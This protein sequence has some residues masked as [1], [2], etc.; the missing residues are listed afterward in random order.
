MRLRVPGDKSL[1]QRALILATLAEGES[2]LSGL[3]HGGDAE[4]TAGALRAL[5]ADIPE[6]PTDGSELRIRGVGLRGLRAPSGPLDLGNS[7]T[8][9]RLLTGVLAGSGC[10]ATLDGDASL[11]SRP[12]ARVTTPLALMGA[13]FEHTAAVGRLPMTVFGKY[14]LEPLDWPSP[15]ASAQ[16]KSAILLAG[17]TGGAFALVTEP[18]ASRDH[19]ERLLRGVGA[20]V[21]SHATS[22]G[23]RVELRD[24]PARIEALDFDI[25]GDV[26]S[27]AFVLALA[28]LG[29]AGDSVT[30]EGVGLNPTRTAFLDVLRRMGADVSVERTTPE[31]APE[32]AGDVHVAPAGLRAVVIGVD[33]VPNLIDELPL[34]AALGARAEGTTRIT[35]AEELRAKES[36]RIHAMV[37]NLRSLGVEVREQPDGLEVTGSDTPL[38]GSVRTF[39]DHRIAMCFG[40][41]GAL[42]DSDVLIDDPSVADVSFPGFAD[43]L[44][45][46][47]A[48]A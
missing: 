5:G 18:R 7:G 21:V 48:V 39:H 15:V 36:D 45:R 22:D 14:P 41:L 34:I 47:Q 10:T 23:W 16:V 40:V 44:S 12:M 43:L 28:A 19:T 30:I 42:V 4:S 17:L 25:P 8:G 37:T 31:D 32:P 20:S 3:L 26:S 2:R 13:R 29:G 27:A 6:L 24:P 38:R 35:G 1:S 33:E 9:T 46:I 11:R